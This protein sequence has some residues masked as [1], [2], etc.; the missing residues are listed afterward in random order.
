MTREQDIEALRLSHD[1]HVATIAALREALEAW[2]TAKRTHEAESGWDGKNGWTAQD[3]AR[4]LAVR[5]AERGL[6]AALARAPQ[7]VVI[8]PCPVTQRTCRDATCRES[9]RLARAPQEKSPDEQ[10]RAEYGFD[11]PRARAPQ[12]GQ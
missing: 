9:C 3:D 5:E 10:F 6:F 12:E 7:A 1:A 11:G 4:R 8:A 2:A